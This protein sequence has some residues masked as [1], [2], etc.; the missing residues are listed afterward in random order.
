MNGDICVSA[1]RNKDNWKN[2]IVM[3]E[4]KRRKGQKQKGATI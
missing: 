3:G 4:W 2:D 1:N